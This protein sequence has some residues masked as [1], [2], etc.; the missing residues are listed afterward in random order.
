MKSVVGEFCSLPNHS[1]DP[2]TRRRREDCKNPNAAGQGIWVDAR[3]WGHVARLLSGGA[4]AH[5]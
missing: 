5:S 4:D 3:R 1:P 2:S